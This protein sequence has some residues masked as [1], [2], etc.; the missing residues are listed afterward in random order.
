M[1]IKKLITLTAMTFMTGNVWGQTDVTSRYIKN[2]DFSDGDALTVHLCGYGADISKTEN[3]L[4]E[5]EAVYG[6]QDVTGWTHNNIRNNTEKK[7]GVAGAGGIF[8]YGSE[9]KLMGNNTAAPALNPAGEKTG[10]ALGIFAVWLGTIQYTQEVTTLPAGWY[11]LTFTYYNQSGETDVTNLFGFEAGEEKYYG[12]TKSFKTGAWKT[13]A[14]LFELKAPTTGKIS[15]GYTSPN[16]GSGSCP[17]L[18][19]DNV[20]LESIATEELEVEN[21]KVGLLSLING[22][23]VPKTN[24]GYDA[25]QYPQEE[26]DKI[27]NALQTAEQVYKNNNATKDD[28]NAQI[29]IVNALTIPALNGPKDDVRYKICVTADN[30]SKTVNNKKTD[31]N[32]KN[33]PITFKAGGQGTGIKDKTD[34]NYD[35]YYSL[36]YMY[37][38]D[39][40]YGQAFQFIPVEG[41]ND[42]YKIS[43][44]G[45]DGKP[46][47]MATQKGAGYQNSTSVAR[48]RVTEDI[49]KALKFRVVATSEEG[50]WNLQNTENKNITI[51]VDD[52]GVFTSKN[53]PGF[54]IAP[55]DQAKATLKIVSDVKYGTFIAPFK[56]D[57]PANVTLYSVEEVDGS[58]LT[59]KKAD[60]IAANTPYI[61]Y[62]D[63]EVT[64]TLQGYGTATKDT[65]EADNLVGTLAGGEMPLGTD[66]YLLQKNND[67]VGFYQC[68]EGKTYTLGPNRAYLQY[69]TQAGVK[70][71]F[72]GE[73]NQTTAITTLSELMNGKAEI[74][75]LNGRKLR[76]L[77][78]G[79]NIV[80]GKKV[81]IK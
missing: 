10:K 29:D 41:D 55:A 39:K 78:K 20:K 56:A 50:V 11:K 71:F 6:S 19:V 22:F 35:G 57:K 46:C 8:A 7:S 18:F 42:M 65:Y 51:G 52:Y 79:I 47:Y 59:L 1:K 69:P 37:E 81:I 45:V 70:A 67:V 77:E 76:K 9:P 28:V 64:E 30:F 80:N 75:D 32:V 72:F 49:N 17:M 25:F 12:S 34:K 62:A 36:T 3:K 24:V 5:N 73:E 66:C 4:N 38:Y 53:R 60:E 23:T 48:I 63:V 21:A 54:N 68:E 15:V 27:N 43:F 74:Y 26:I 2:A 13:E 14:V 31:F 40:N 58:T 16:A 61:V 44:T 33:H